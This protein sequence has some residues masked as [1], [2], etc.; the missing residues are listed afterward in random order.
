MPEPGGSCVAQIRI[1]L[2][3]SGAVSLG[4]F[5]GGALAALIT[6]VQ[7]TQA[8]GGRPALRIDAIGGASAGSI[9]GVA[10]ARALTGGVDPIWMME[11]AWVVKDSLQELLGK[12]GGS[13]STPAPLSMEGLT[14]LAEGVISPPP[15]RVVASRIQPCPVRVH[16]ALTNL[17]GLSYEIKQL[18]RGDPSAW[19]V[20]RATTYLDWGIFT[21]EPGAS[22]SAFLDAPAQGEASA[23]DTALASGASPLGFPPKLL[24]RSRVQYASAGVDN[25][26]ARS[27]SLWF[28]D[29]GTIDNEPLGRTLDLTNEIDAADEPE[30]DCSRVHVLIHPFP[31]FPPPPG[32]VIWANPKRSPTFLATLVRAFGIIR[33]QNLYADIRSAEKANSRLI[34]QQSLLQ[35]VG[36]LIDQMPD[37]EKQRWAARLRDVVERIDEDRSHL[38]RHRKHPSDPATDGDGSPQAIFEEA[39][40][41]VSGLGSKNIVGIEVVSPYLAQG[42]AG[43][44]LDQLLAGEFLFAFGGFFD[45]GLRR[46][47]FALGYVS[48]LNW[49]TEA[50]PRYG[51]DQAAVE[52]ALE[53]AIRGFFALAPWTVRGETRTFA[54]YGLSE[55]ALERAHGLG[56]SV[57]DSWVPEHFSKT[58][59][60]SLSIG[61]QLAFAGLLRRAAAVLG[62][63]AVMKWRGKDDPR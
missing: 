43:K 62:R 22:P 55:A 57:S 52:L 15:E 1:G 23:V 36:D 31:D 51:L 25:L 35:V 21:F 45:E 11:Q 37:S 18:R 17:R 54:G 4:A 24:S 30:R 14:A 3:I 47:D 40:E 58:T 53:G 42:T 10:A 2:T 48:M 38:P 59:P 29:G 34:W 5:E 60:A 49:M 27:D 13:A 33:S 63:D 12:P 7:A 41:R 20:I 32:D 28:T 26:P 16:L 39:L 19:P 50:L 56:L 46:S 9:T 6:A 8:L 61:G 44:P